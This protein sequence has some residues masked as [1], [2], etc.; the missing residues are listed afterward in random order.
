MSAVY[1][2]AHSKPTRPASDSIT[3]PRLSSPKRGSVPNS[4]T[5]ATAVGRQNPVTSAST[6]SAVTNSK[7]FS[8]SAL[9][10]SAQTGQ[11]GG[12]GGGQRC[13]CPQLVQA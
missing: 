5:P 2:G 12:P 4:V 6:C 7:P 11:A 1:Q 10:T 8:G 3:H 13:Q 9:R